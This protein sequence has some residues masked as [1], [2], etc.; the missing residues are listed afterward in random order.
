MDQAREVPEQE[1][2]QES[3]QQAIA[4]MHSMV[5]EMQFVQEHENA[6]LAGEDP[7]RFVSH[8]TPSEA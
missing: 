8:S 4:R 1:R 6:V 7:P 3:S 5:D 2:L